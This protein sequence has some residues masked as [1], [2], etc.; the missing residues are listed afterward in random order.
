MQKD[1]A[2]TKHCLAKLK[3]LPPPFNKKM[4][5]VSMISEKL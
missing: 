4:G 3:F 5:Y 2:A 1:K